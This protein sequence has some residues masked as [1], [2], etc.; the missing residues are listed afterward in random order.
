MHN[1]RHLHMSR[2]DFRT[3]Q[4]RGRGWSHIQDRATGTTCSVPI[5]SLINEMVIL[6]SSG[7]KFESSSFTYSRWLTETAT[8]TYSHLPFVNTW[9]TCTLRR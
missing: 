7:I 9:G 4:A 1:Q 2:G 5:S 8:Y 3:K 6:S